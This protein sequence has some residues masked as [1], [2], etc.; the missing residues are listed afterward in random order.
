LNINKYFREWPAVHFVY[1]NYKP[2]VI[3]S[4]GP[5]PLNLIG[6]ILRSPNL[7]MMDAIRSYKAIPDMLFY[8]FDTIY[9]KYDNLSFV[10]WAKKK[11][12][13]PFYDIIMQPAL[14]LTLNERSSFSAA[15][16]LSFMQIYFLMS[17]DSDHREVTTVNYRDAVLKPWTDRLLNL[18]VK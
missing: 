10:D 13:Q 17:S 1:R 18:G 12:S 8:D 3:Y 5:Y 2:E 11:V 14:S 6:I 7:S 15:E 9:K 4:K 16:M